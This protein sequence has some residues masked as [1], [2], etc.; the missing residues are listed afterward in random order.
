[1]IGERYGVNGS[2]LRRQYK[3]VISDFSNWKQRV[4]AHEYILFPKN[5]GRDLSLDETCLS[6][7]EVY[8]V[9]TN[10][11]AHGRK[12]CL[13]AMIRGVATDTVS[14]I[15]K[16]IPLRYRRKVRTVT[17]DLSS[18]MMLTVRTVFPSATLVND[19]FHVQQLFSE[20]IDRLRIHYRWEV[21][22]EENKAI[23]AHRRLRASVKDAQARAALG[24]WEPERMANGETL[25]QIMSRSRHVILRHESKWNPSQQVRAS[26]L[27]G[28]FPK[29]KKAYDLYLR[30]I[31]IFNK[32]S[33]P[34]VARLSLAK[35]YNEV[36]AFGESTFNKILETFRL[37]NP[38]IINY[39][40]R[41]LTNASAESF[42]AKI[43]ALRSQFRGVSDIAFF[44]YRL[45]N[46]YS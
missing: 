44:M 42:N 36:E 41:R 7:G 40:E 35:W 39:F 45:A 32:K 28:R 27:F 43:K 17:T 33:T 13:I 26:I 20:A 11:D 15:L 8:T 30:L 24:H 5:V 9:L 23:E 31:D 2:T 21:L 3:D 4:H 14:A 46:I 16:R 37:H 1:M 19:R 34:S 29:L 12:G 25:P 38:T 6:D 22:E 18:A 10:K